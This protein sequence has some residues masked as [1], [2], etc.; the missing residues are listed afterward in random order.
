MEVRR[1]PQQS[2]TATPDLQE[3]QVHHSDAGLRPALAWYEALKEADAAKRCGCVEGEAPNHDELYY[4]V[5][6]SFDSDPSMELDANMQNTATFS[7]MSDFTR[8]A[9]LAS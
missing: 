5:Y 6:P 2:S 7:M 4:L 1:R 3:R 9:P 8:Y